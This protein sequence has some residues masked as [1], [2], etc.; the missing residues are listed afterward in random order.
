[1][2]DHNDRHVNIDIFFVHSCN[3]YIHIFLFIVPSQG[4]TEFDD[5]VHIVDSV[6]IDFWLFDILLFIIDDIYISNSFDIFGLH[7]KMS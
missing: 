7:L 4:C 6:D 1:M 5:I 3:V 2:D